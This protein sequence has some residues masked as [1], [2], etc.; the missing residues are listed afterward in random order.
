MNYFD[1]FS[2]FWSDYCATKGVLLFLLSNLVIQDKKLVFN[3]KTP[4]DVIAECSQNQSWLT[5]IEEVMIIVK[6]Y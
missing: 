3:L 4:F 2:Q 1:D 6:Q 5:T